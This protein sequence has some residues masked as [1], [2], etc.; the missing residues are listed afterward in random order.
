MTSRVRWAWVRVWLPQ[1]SIT[2]NRSCPLAG[3]FE[4][5]ITRRPSYTPRHVSS[6][7]LIKRVPTLDA[8]VPIAQQLHLLSLF[9]PASASAALLEQSHT[10]GAANGAKAT[11]GGDDAAQAMS[12]AVRESPYEALHSV[13][14]N[15]MAPWFDAYVASKE[16]PEKQSTTATLKNKDNDA[17]MG[18]Y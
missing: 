6:I 12:A 14:H 1:L 15:V 3:F 13:V 7:A 5:Q 10:N 11:D 16:G 2:D 17:R 4:F 18:E 8:D 9:G